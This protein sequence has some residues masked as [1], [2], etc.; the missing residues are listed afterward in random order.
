MKRTLTIA[1]TAALTLS[2]GLAACGKKGNLQDP[3]APQQ[4]EQA[5]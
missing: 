2:L 4:E 5:S 3:P 1:L